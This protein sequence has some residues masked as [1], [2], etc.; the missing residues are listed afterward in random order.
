M[1]FA[2]RKDVKPIEWIGTQR[3]PY[4]HRSKQKKM[5][6]LATK[7]KKEIAEQASI[8]P[9]KQLPERTDEHMFSDCD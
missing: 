8:A 9:V 1:Q 5:E 2:D 7:A 4:T 3:S 6:Q